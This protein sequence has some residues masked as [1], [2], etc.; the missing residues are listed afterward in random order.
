[1]KQKIKILIVTLA[2]SVSGSFAVLGVLSQPV[3]A[4][5]TAGDGNCAEK[6]SFSFTCIDPNTNTKLEST[7][8]VSISCIVTT[9]L[10]F[11]S[12]AVGIAVVAG[13]VV[14][15]ITYSTAGGNPAKVKKGGAIIGSAIGGLVL[16]ILMYAI[17]NF[18]LPKGTLN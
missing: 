18:L 17:I 13:I 3:S 5:C 7:T 6:T 10:N 12:V 11:L 2:L 1:M 16:F 4:V 15:G 9:V 8:D 14:G